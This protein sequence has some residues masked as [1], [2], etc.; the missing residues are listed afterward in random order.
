L[1][2]N[3]LCVSLEHFE[4]QMRLVRDETQPIPLRELAVR[5]REGNLQQA[6][7][8]VTFDDGYADNWMN[9]APILRELAIPA[10]FFVTSGMV[11]TGR[12]FFADELIHLTL[13]AP[14][15]PE[16]LH[17][18]VGGKVLRL[19]GKERPIPTTHRTW[20][21]EGPNLI[22]PA[23]REELYHSLHSLLR[24]ENLESRESILTELREQVAWPPSPS[25]ESHRTLSSAQLR[26]LVR[27]NLF[28]VGAHAV[29]H[30]VLRRLP[31]EEQAFQI[32]ESKTQL[33]LILSMPVESFAYPYGSEWDVSPTTVDL[34]R[35]AG[36]GLACAN[37]P[38]QVSRG[39]DP[40]W[41]PRYLVRDWGGAEF[42]RRLR[43][44]FVPRPAARPVSA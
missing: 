1:D 24:E 40:Y 28:E 9:A 18:S 7:V 11:D 5:L 34:V 29:E 37:V 44:F 2:P 19:A 20:T 6:G 39:S 31:S 23:P 3:Q 10:T 41:L 36:F 30:L 16:E 32:R 14:I 43:S 33:E 13:S 38:G 4:K 27:E 17:V 22:D 12:E 8:V 25:C 26:D 15:L 35:Q 42:G 21:G